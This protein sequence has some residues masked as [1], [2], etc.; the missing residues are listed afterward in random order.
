MKQTEVLA[1]TYDF[2]SML[3]EEK[4][5]KNSIK[6]LILF[7]SV[8]RENFDDESDIDLF[9][10]VKQSSNEKEIERII[11]ETINRF[12]IVAEKTW[13]LRNINLPIKVIVGKEEDPTWENLKEEIKHYGIVLYGEYKEQK[14]N[15]A[16]ISYSLNK[17]KQNEKMNCLRMLYG[18]TSKK[19]KKVYSKKGILSAIG[20]IKTASNQIM[21]KLD[22]TKD[23]LDVLNE[24]KVPHKV[25]RILA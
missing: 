3:L 18:Y 16:L 24:F 12:E 9:F 4:K 2:I 20:A 7:G 23:I 5:I 15:H 25:M 19:K 21:V 17:L 8:A 11:K 13:N 10:E 1:Y 6:Q 22:N 14:E